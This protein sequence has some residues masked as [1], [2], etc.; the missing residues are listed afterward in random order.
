[1]TDLQK[2]AA[3]LDLCDLGQAF[4]KGRAKAK[5]TAH[6]KACY[7]AIREMNERDGLVDMSDDEL[8]VELGV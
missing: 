1:M 6:R 3:D 2:I 5:F 8:L 7:D 4:A